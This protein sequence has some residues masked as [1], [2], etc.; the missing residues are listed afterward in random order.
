VAALAVALTLAVFLLGVLVI[1]LLRSHAD[2]LRALHSLGAGIGDPTAD[3]AAGG[4]VGPVPIT[5]GTTL[6]SERGNG[7]TDLAG[8]TPTGDALAVAMTSADLTLLAFLSSGCGT[9][10]TFW[11]GLTDP[12]VVGLPVG[13]RL[14]FVTKGPELESPDLVAGLAPSGAEVVLATDAWVDYEVPAAP[15]FVLVDGRAGRRVGE[16]LASTVDQ[17]AGLFQRVVADGNHRARR[18]APTHLD[19]GEREEDNDQALLASGITPGDPSLYP[20]SPHG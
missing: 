16:G 5:L 20:S 4:S 1:G 9:C 18:P 17:L 11:K 19:G 3:E 13:T 14:V 8:S 15:F 10:H 12:T 7:V 2:I 6:P